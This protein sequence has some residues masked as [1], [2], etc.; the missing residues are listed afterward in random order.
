MIKNR[1]RKKILK[2]RNLKKIYDLKLDL[3]KLLLLFKKK[4]IQ[5]KNVGGYFPVNFEINS[6]QILKELEKKKI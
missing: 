6:L 1:L 4:K 5:K 3:K 2:L